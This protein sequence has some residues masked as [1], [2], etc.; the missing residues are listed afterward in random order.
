LIDLSTLNKFDKQG[1]YKIY[2]RWPQIAKEAYES[3]PAP[4]GFTCL[5]FE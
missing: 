3:D 1:M 2:D 5:N 4:V